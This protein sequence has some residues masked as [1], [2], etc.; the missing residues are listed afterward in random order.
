MKDNIHIEDEED[1]CGYTAPEY[2]YKIMGET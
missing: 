2:N 1:D